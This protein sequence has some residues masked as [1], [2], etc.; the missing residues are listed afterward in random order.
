MA[1]ETL[2]THT[3]ARRNAL[4]AA[5]ESRKVIGIVVT[6]GE[7]NGCEDNEGDLNDLAKAHFDTQGIPIFFIGMDGLNEGNLEEMALGTGADVHDTCPA[8]GTACA[9]DE[10]VCG[11]LDECSFYSIG[12]GNFEAFNTALDAIRESVSGCDFA[13]PAGSGLVDLNGVS[14]TFTPGG[15]SAETLT[16]VANEGACSANDE[17]F[18]EGTGNDAIIKL[19]PTT[20][21]RNDDDATVDIVIPCQ[22]Q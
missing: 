5:G 21:E 4:T 14:V 11:S 1:I 15:G 17:Y 10:K 9:D 16:S 8:G 2:K 12:N 22:G 18:V 19:C 13:I 7:P 6:D 20:C 3:L